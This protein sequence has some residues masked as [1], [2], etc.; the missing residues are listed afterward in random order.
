MADLDTL[1][2]ILDGYRPGAT[3]SV[4]SLRDDLEAAQIKPSQYGG[5]FRTAVEREWLRPT[6]RIANSRKGS[7]R[8]GVIREYK[9]TRRAA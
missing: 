4:D 5:L 1:R 8:H 7:R 3:L 2:Q 9:V 6:G